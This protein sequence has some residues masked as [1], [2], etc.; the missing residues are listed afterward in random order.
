MKC[1]K[2]TWLRPAGNSIK[3]LPKGFAFLTLGFAIL[4]G[5]RKNDGLPIPSHGDGSDQY[6]S[7]DMVLTWNLQIQKAYTF[8]VNVGFP[9]P[10][11]SRL[12]AM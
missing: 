4:L 7:P 1:Y 6:V 2:L 9:P 5:C 11:I 10:I 12:F 8:P 3:N